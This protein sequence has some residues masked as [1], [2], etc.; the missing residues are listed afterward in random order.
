MTDRDAT[1]GALKREIIALCRR[2]GWGDDGIQNPQHICMAMMVEACEV[3]EHFQDMTQEDER[4]LTGGRMPAEKQ[5]IAEEVADVL[6]YGFQ[7]MHTLG[8]D[9]SRGLDANWSDAETPVRTL[10]EAAGAGDRGPV[11]RA[12]HMLVEARRVLERMQWLPED[13]VRAMIEGGLPGTRRAVG[14]AFCG[15]FREILMLARLL[16]FD[17]AGEIARKIAI[18]ERRAYGDEP[19]R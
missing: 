15:L 8:V 2:K 16:G 1:V 17:L 9:V 5:E 12:M 3:L 18:V 11:S 19:A 14:E 4:A 7:I 10:K 13:D 6:M